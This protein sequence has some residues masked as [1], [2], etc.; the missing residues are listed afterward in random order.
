MNEI[1]KR[2]KMD[3]ANM[4]DALNRLVLRNKQIG[5]KII[6]KIVNKIY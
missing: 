6:A 4:D 3:S 2:H 5:I 1:H